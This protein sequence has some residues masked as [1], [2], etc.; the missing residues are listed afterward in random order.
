M[1][2][3]PWTTSIQKLDC[4]SVGV[5]LTDCIRLWPP[6]LLEPGTAGDDPCVRLGWQ[7][8]IA[9]AQV[10]HVVTFHLFEGTTSTPKVPEPLVLRLL[11][12]V[13]LAQIPDSGMLEVCESLATLFSFYTTQPTATH[14]LIQ[15]AK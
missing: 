12:H 7:H 5:S 1:P 10:R 14:A 9:V 2:V 11:S 6:G 3:E 4:S 8:R 13:L 15:T